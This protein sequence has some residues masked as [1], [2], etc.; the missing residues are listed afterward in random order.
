MPVYN[1]KKYMSKSINSVL[2]QTL[3][4][5]ELICIN[6]FSTDGSLKKLKEFQKKDKRIRIINNDK[7]LGP[8]KSRNV[9]ISKAA[10]K[11][12]C[13]V[14]SDD[15]LEKN[16][17][18]ILFKKAELENADIIYIKPKLVFS[19]KII[20]DK[21][22]LTKKELK[23]IDTVFRKNLLRKIAWAPWSKMV[24]RDI[25]IKNKI[26]FPDIH[27]AEDMD[28]SSKVIYYSKK[29][30]CADE[31]LYNYYLREGSLMSFS[32]SKRRIENYFESIKL[33]KNFLLSKA[34]FQK[35]QKEFT[36]FKLYNYL[37]ISGV[38]C[39]S[40]EK[41]DKKKY[42]KLIKNDPD[43]NFLKILNL[44]I[45]DS[46]MIGAILLKFNLFNF[47]LKS[48]DSLQI[49]FGKWGKRNN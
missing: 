8:G 38:M 43:F 20:L 22:L 26:K 6:D 4:E 19:D 24:K 29:I 49:L 21:R 16:S 35:Y 12:I 10:G 14:D 23:N 25:I 33:L 7:N 39:Y 36:Y 13:F 1:S 28:F 15:W 2:T 44:G 5:I 37:A 32:N 17:C 27:I 45:F 3:K 42:R 40:K 46:V 34:I 11:Y 31:Y 30:S 18:E 47:A 41:L 48:R 9:A